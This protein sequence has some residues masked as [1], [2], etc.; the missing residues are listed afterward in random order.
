MS[1]GEVIVTTAVLDGLK[2]VPAV[3]I[4]V[5]LVVVICFFGYRLLRLGLLLYRVFKNTTWNSQEGYEEFRQKAINMRE[6]YERQPIVAELAD[7]ENET[8][9]QETKVPPI[10][11]K[12]VDPDDEP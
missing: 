4:T 9:L 11:A 6:Q 2:L 1:E 3:I 8:K 5:G 7:T 10:I 12:L